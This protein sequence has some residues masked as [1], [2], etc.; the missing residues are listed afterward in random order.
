[1][2]IRW[3]L[4]GLVFLVMTGWG[5]MAIMYSDLPDGLRLAAAAAFAVSA[6][7]SVIIPQRTGWKIAFYSLVFALVLAWWLALLPRNDREWQPDVATLSS[8]TINGSTVTIHNIRNC[9]YHTESDYIVRHYNRTF[10]LDSLRSM[11]LFLVDWGAPLI[12]HTM[13]SFGFEG[14]RYI[15]FSIE[16]RKTIGEE[17]S[18]I[19]GFFKQYELITVVADE[20]DVVRLRANYRSGEDVYL[21]RLKATPEL[22]R[23]VFMDYLRS[24]NRLR[25]KPEWYNAL[26][27][28]CTTGIWRHIAPFYPKASF[29]WRIIASGRVDEM[30]YELGTMDQTFHFQELKQRSRIN[31]RSMAADR[32]WA[33]SMRIRRGLPGF[34]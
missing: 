15:C 16:T 17:Y 27:V 14:D 4:A 20:R 33:F 25:E 8:A 34:K 18:A 5:I 22:I 3:I 6:L 21:Y 9:D 28:N 2:R 31:E 26:T 19:K 24:I 12:A 1:M 23:L 7:G 29:D 30:A 32:E 13:L 11:D 10:N